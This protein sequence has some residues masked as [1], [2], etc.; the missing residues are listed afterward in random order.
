LLFLIGEQGE[1]FQRGDGWIKMDKS[2]DLLKREWRGDV[3]RG[4]REGGV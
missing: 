3:D 2:G 1:G 4:R